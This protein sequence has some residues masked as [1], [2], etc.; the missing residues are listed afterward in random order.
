[1]SVVPGMYTIQNVMHR[2]IAAQ[3][4][5]DTVVADTD[6]DSGGLSQRVLWT[7]SP[8][9]NGKFTI[10]NIETNDYAGFRSL[11]S[12]DDIIVAKRTR[13]NWEIKETGFKGRFVIYTSAA[14]IDLFWGLTNGELLHPVSL[15]NAPNHPGNQWLLTKVASRREL[16]HE[17]LQLRRKLADL[18]DENTKLRDVVELLKA[19][20]LKTSADAQRERERYQQAEAELKAH[21]EKTFAEQHAEYQRYSEDMAKWREREERDRITQ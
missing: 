14:E 8:L 5:E 19:D 10:K 13:Q 11:P 15:R 4:P 18:E 1:M 7:I 12:T 21:Y 9:M 20:A 6:T 2:N 16:E 17:T 3:S